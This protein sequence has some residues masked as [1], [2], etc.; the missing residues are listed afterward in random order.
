LQDQ[1]AFREKPESS[2]PGIGKGAETQEEDHGAE[3]R[4]THSAAGP[5]RREGG[6][7]NLTVIPSDKVSDPIEIPEDV[8]VCPYCG[9][10]LSVSP[11]CWEQNEDG[12]W[13]LSNGHADCAA[14][15][16]IAGEE[17]KWEEWFTVHSQMPYV[18]QLPVDEKCTAWIN[19]RYRFEMD[20]PEGKC[21]TA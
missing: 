14:E 10:K 11:E 15:P 2:Q 16:D 21:S 9:A 20:V 3:H 8:A 5:G 1:P 13:S 12:S 19:E 17:E 7:M 18:Y 4:G 6:K